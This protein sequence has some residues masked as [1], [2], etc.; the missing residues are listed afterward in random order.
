[1]RWFLPPPHT[2]ECFSSRRCPAEVLRV[3]TMLTGNPATRF[4]YSA[5]AVA[6]PLMWQTKFKAVRSAARMLRAC[7]SPRRPRRPA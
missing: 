4:T 6:I 1:M 3:S 5:V 2:T 7:R